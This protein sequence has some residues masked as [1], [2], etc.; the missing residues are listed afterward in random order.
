MNTN[1]KSNPDSLRSDTIE[2]NLILLNWW[3][4]GSSGYKS[5]LNQNTHLAKH[6][7][8]ADQKCRKTI[9]LEN[10]KENSN[11]QSTTPPP[12]ECPR[13]NLHIELTFHFPRWICDCD[14]CYFLYSVALSSSS[15]YN[16]TGNTTLRL[17]FFCNKHITVKVCYGG[18]GKRAFK[19]SNPIDR[20][21]SSIEWSRGRVTTTNGGK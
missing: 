9:S 17:L 12:D 8:R 3:R 5:G 13:I 19:Q 7:F 20:V 1:T 18:C 14:R 11:N 2:N 15:G 10:R 4:C 16:L 6:F 21:Y